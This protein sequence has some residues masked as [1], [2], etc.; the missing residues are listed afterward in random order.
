MKRYETQVER[1]ERSTRHANALCYA[2]LGLLAL[3]V[4]FIYSR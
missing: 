1:A 2:L 3:L 4:V